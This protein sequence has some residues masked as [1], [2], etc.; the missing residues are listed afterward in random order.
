MLIIKFIEKVLGSLVKLS[1]VVV[2]DNTV[3]FSFPVFTRYSGLSA[4]TQRR[5]RAQKLRRALGDVIKLNSGKNDQTC[6]ASSSVAAVDE[7]NVEDTPSVPIH[8][9]EPDVELTLEQDF[10]RVVVERGLGRD[11]VNEMFSVF[12]KHNIGNFPSDARSI[13]GTE[14][15]SDIVDMCQG[16]YY[17]FGLSNQLVRVLQGMK[18]EEA[19]T[20]KLKFNFDGLPIWNS[21]G[22]CFWP[23]LSQAVV[24]GKTSRVFL[25][26][27]YGG[28]KKPEKANKYLE[29]F[30]EEVSELVRTPFSVC[31]LA[32]NLEVYCI[33]ADAPA[34]CFIK[35]IKYFNSDVGCERCTVE[36]VNCQDIVGKRFLD[37]DKRLRTNEGFRAQ[38]DSDHHHEESALCRLNIDMV[39]SFPLDYMHL[40][41]L[42][43]CR[44]CLYTWTGKEY[45][46]PNFFIVHGIGGPPLKIVN[47]KLTKKCAPSMCFEFQRRPRSLDEVRNFKATEFRTILVYLF[48]YVFKNSFPAENVY[49]HFLL[50][51]VAMRILLS[52]NAPV[53]LVEY[54]RGLL[55]AFVSSSPRFYGVSFLIYNTHNLIHLADDYLKFGYLDSVSCFPFESY[56]F[57]LKKYVRRPGHEV[58]QVVRRVKEEQRLLPAVEPDLSDCVRLRLAHLSGPL[59]QERNEIFTQYLEATLFGKRIRPSS[60]DDTVFCS[61][62]FC[63]VCNI[64]RL[65]N[66][67]LLVV[68]RYKLVRDVFDYP[69]KSSKVGI[70]FCGK[71]DAKLQEVPIKNVTKCLRVEIDKDWAYTAK[72]LHDS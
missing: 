47:E 52:V 5:R 20:V 8:V 42:G 39:R 70:V 31:N 10:A 28:V 72:L 25:V 32:V 60:S 62:G 65:N 9:N 44:R 55:R 21:T 35:C 61:I 40:V 26:G 1:H 64:I 57:R 3:I 56:M 24:L 17:H 2:S 27:L 23:I 12:R 6:V 45:K 50:L 59:A 43:V 58:A 67:V 63:R 15:S 16:L 54:A 53:D 19:C 68:R 46:N 69:C 13:L 4:R 66:K 37:L 18:I 22:Y 41:M 48:P 33:L 7:V 29:P 11:T 34:R 14:R 71:L 51:V 36:A 30:V 38:I 49:N